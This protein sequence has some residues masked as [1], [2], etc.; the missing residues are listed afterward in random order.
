MVIFIATGEL[1]P[2]F[3]YCDELYQRC[4]IKIAIHEIWH[5]ANAVDKNRL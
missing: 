1:E 2:M 3:A 4:F 5:I